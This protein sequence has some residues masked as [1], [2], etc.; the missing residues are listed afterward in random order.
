MIK[1]N[2]GYLQWAL[3][4]FLT[5]TGIALFM[6][7]EVIRPYGGDFLVVIMLYCLM[8]GIMLI[9]IIT[10]AMLVLLFSYVVETL[11]YFKIVTVL[12][13]EKSQIASTLIGTCFAWS[14]IMAYTLGIL[15]VILV[16]ITLKRFQKI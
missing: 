5:E 11:Q 9:N 1:L 6:R 12:G 16:E 4:L 7:D 3:L 15:C 10:T 8:R 2:P 13:L 14:D